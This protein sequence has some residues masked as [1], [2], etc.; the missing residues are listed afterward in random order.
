LSS[1]RFFSIKAQDSEG[2]K[3]EIPK[4][5]FLNIPSIVPETTTTTE[6][7]TTTTT[8]PSDTTTTTNPAGEIICSEDTYNC[9]DFST[10]AEAQEVFESCGGISNDIHQ[11]DSDKDGTACEGLL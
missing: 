4:I 6:P 1:W 8:Q 9:S 10:H 7:R 5:F 11:P 3:S 2:L